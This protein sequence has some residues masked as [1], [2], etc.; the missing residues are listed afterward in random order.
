[1]SNPLTDELEV[2]KT[3]YKIYIIMKELAE[4]FYDKSNKSKYIKEGIEDYE[5]MKKSMIE[6]I[7]NQP[8]EGFSKLS[9]DLIEGYMEK[10]KKFIEKEYLNKK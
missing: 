1:M 7:H 5:K 10:K 3:S 6:E 8:F 2:P 9:K 4:H